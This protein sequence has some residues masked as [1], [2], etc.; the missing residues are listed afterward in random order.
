MVP[1]HIIPNCKDMEH[2]AERKIKVILCRGAKHEAAQDPKPR[3]ERRNFG[4]EKEEG[5]ST[6]L[7]AA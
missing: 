7:S 2:E 4:M 1:I 3:E 5:R 6:T